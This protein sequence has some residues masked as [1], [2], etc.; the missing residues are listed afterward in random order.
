MRACFSSCVIPLLDEAEAEAFAARLDLDLDRGICHACLSFVSVALD[1][2]VVCEI[3]RQ[4]RRMTP[5]LWEEGL[6]TTKALAAAERACELGTPHAREALADLEQRGGK[7]IVA[8]AIVRRLADQLS[9]RVSTRR[10]E[11]EMN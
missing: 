6:D 9:A 8:R 11:A 5:D 3:G 4:L 7:S 2:G 10:R 1:G